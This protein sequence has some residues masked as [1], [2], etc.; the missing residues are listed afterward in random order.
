M[1]V[2]EYNIKTTTHERNDDDD[3]QT[4][5]S[6]LSTSDLV[7][8]VTNAKRK[9]RSKQPR[10]HA[11]CVRLSSA[12]L[13]LPIASSLR[14]SLSLSLSRCASAR[15][16][17]RPFTDGRGRFASCLSRRARHLT[18]K[19]IRRRE[20][21]EAHSRVVR[22]YAEGEKLRE[23]STLKADESRADRV[24]ESTK[25]S[26]ED[27]DRHASS[28]TRRIDSIPR[29]LYIHAPRACYYNRGN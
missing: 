25:F 8:G 7:V 9:R 19:V 11:L 17:P 24:S 28:C 2:G 23:K 16:I 15:A 27:C 14:D 20:T 13:F 5:E 1:F 12:S 4:L 6:S 26:N 21:G 18:V 29:P 3:A 22:R 10:R